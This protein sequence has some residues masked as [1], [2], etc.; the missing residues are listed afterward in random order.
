[1]TDAIELREH[2]FDPEVLLHS[3][4]QPG[5]GIADQERR[6]QSVAA[7]VAEGEAHLV[8]RHVDEVAEVSAHF[9]HRDG[10]VRHVEPGQPGRLLPQE[11]LLD[12]GHL[13]E[14][15]TDPIL[16]QVQPE[17]R[18]QD[19]EREV[20]SL[21]VPAPVQDEEQEAAVGSPSDHHAG[22]G[23]AGMDAVRGR[24][25]RLAGVGEDVHAVTEHERHGGPCRLDE[26]GQRFH[27]LSDPLAELE[28]VSPLAV[29]QDTSQ[30]EILFVGAIPPRVP[31]KGRGSR[32][33]RQPMSAA[34]RRS[35]PRE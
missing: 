22:R 29:D 19:V 1:M 26:L 31:R 4:P 12:L 18:A 33:E 6:R 30:A 10:P 16:E 27:A 20:H 21:P 28:A 9:L 24:G 2:V 25:V 11:A 32:R 35:R 7:G 34:A 17:G 8:F 5:D 3:H 23:P 15:E 13:A 14:A